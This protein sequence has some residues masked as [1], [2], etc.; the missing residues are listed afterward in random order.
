M[1]EAQRQHAAALKEASEVYLRSLGVKNINIPELDMRNRVYMDYMSVRI[2]VEQEPLGSGSADPVG[3]A[4]SSSAR[5]G[6][7]KGHVHPDTYFYAMDHFDFKMNSH[8]KYV[9]DQ[10]FLNQ[11][12]QGCLDNENKTLIQE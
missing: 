8:L 3:G 6:G 4:G 10:F 9:W 2:F 1:A 11:T 12:I 7:Q 5:K